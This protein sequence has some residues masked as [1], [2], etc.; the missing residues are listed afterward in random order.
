MAVASAAAVVATMFFVPGQRG[1]GQGVSQVSGFV[2]VTGQHYVVSRL[3]RLED[4]VYVPVE[5]RRKS[6]SGTTDVLALAF[7]EPAN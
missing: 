5:H 2:G 4:G 6:V 1:R 3:G 7:S